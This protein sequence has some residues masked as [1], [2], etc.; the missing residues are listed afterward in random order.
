MKLLGKSLLF[1]CPKNVAN[2]T[3]STSGKI[4]YSL[5]HG[6]FG[7]VRKYDRVEGAKKVKKLIANN[8]ARIHVLMIT[9][10]EQS[11]VKNP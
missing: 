1:C 6:T 8:K 2:Y 9:Q 3:V 4:V 10:S 11:K 7:E 5:V